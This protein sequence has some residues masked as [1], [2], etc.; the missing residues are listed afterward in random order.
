MP[1]RS[2]EAGAPSWHDGGRR[3][4]SGRT[5]SFSYRSGGGA[6]PAARRGNTYVE[7]DTGLTEEELA[8]FDRTVG[9]LRQLPADDPVRL[10]AERVASSFARE[11]RH[12]RRKAC[13]EEQ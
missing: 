8:A 6:G 4:E 3:F 11:G 2:A 1:V 13:R 10:R 12:R 7:G 9:K 5:G